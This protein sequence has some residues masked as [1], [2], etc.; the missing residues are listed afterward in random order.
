LTTSAALIVNLLTGRH[1]TPYAT[2]GAG[3]MSIVGDLP[4]ATLAGNYQFLNPSGAPFNES[5]TVV[6]TDARSRHSVAGVLG[7]GLKCDVSPHWGVR[8]DV[9]VALS[10]N[11]S[12][13][14]LDATPGVLLGQLPAGRVTL[15]SDPTIQFG[16]SSGPV[17]G[18]GTTALAPSSLSGPALT[19]ITLWK[20]SG[21][22][23][24]TTAAFGVY[25]RF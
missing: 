16:N 21:T 14:D 20:G 10:K 23:A 19:N 4:T 3:V 24:L 1:I 7:G 13:T 18:L 12:Q 11:G 17:T 22:S 9:R 5:D 25:R 8:L 2:L 15:N 6:V